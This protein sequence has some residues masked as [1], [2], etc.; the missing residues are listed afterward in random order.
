MNPTQ[1]NQQSFNGGL[2]GFMTSLL[3]AGLGVNLS[4]VSVTKG[5]GGRVLITVPVDDAASIPGD[6]NT[7]ANNVTITPVGTGANIQFSFNANMSDVGYSNLTTA[8]QIGTSSRYA[9]NGESSGRDLWIAPDNKNY[10]FVDTGAKTIHQGDAAIKNSDDIIIAGGGADSINAGTGW[11]W[12]S[13]G[14]GNDTLYGGDQDDTIFGGTGNDVIYGGSGM[15]YI[16]GGAGADTIHGA[17]AGVAASDTNFTDLGTASYAS[18]HAG[19]QINLTTGTATGGHATGDKISFISNLVGSKYNDKLVGEKDTSNWLEGGAGADTL[20]GGGG[21]FDADR[22]SYIHASKGVVASLASPKS[23]TGDA[24]GDVYISIEG[25]HGSRFADT[26][27]GD[28]GNNVLSGDAGDDVLVAGIGKDTINGGDG[29]DTL[30]YRTLSAGVTINV[31]NWSLSSAEVANDTIVYQTTGKSGIEAYEGTNF[32]DTLLGST[33]GDTLIG[34]SGNDNINGRQGNDVLRGD[35]GNDVLN[36]AEGNDR[37][38]GGSGNDTLIGGTGNDTLSGDAGNDRLEGGSGIDTALF[39]GSVSATVNLNITSAQNTGYGTDTLI[40][41]ENLI[42]SD[43]ADKLTGNGLNN[44]LRGGAGNDTISGGAGADTITGG[45]GKDALY[46]GANDAA[47]DVFVFKA[48]SDSGLGSTHRDKVYNFV[49]GTDDFDFQTIDANTK[50]GGDQAFGFSGT[51]AKAN[52]VWYTD[53]GSDLFLRG[54]VNGDSKADFEIY[55]AGIN[56]LSKD[57]FLL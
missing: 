26:L 7:F 56:S 54:D 15:D 9:V 49:S 23:N 18:S 8:T 27:M 24:A 22:A 55:V 13:G 29:I 32:N 57:D 33:A 53:A 5:T 43:A 17:T 42:G 30:S 1:T 34:R 4:L 11:D 44:S 14:G 20:D 47:R 51:T 39:S 16:E 10:T 12:I 2:G 38:N 31:E 3:N 35:G 36:G 52:S 6:I 41:I 28:N 46:G 48:V 37:L 45:A 25:L 40:G 21:A 19:V 50:V